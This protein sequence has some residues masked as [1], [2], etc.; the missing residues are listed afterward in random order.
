LVLEKDEITRRV[1]E[2]ESQLA[3][4]DELQAQLNDVVARQD[5]EIVALRRQLE[6]LAKRLTDLGEALPG[7][8]SGSQDDTPPHY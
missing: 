1:E 4:Q 5:R 8:H 7:E 3:F 2:L 6:E